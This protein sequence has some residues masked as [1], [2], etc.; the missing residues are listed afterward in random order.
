MAGV[1]QRAEE[2]H[3]QLRQ[4]AVV[5]HR[6]RDVLLAV[7]HPDLAQVAAIGAQ[8]RHLSPLDAA[9]QTSWLSTPFSRSPFHNS[10]QA[11]LDQRLGL[12]ERRL[13]LAGGLRAKS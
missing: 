4:L 10:P 8:Q 6:L 2:A 12:L 13:L 11:L 9:E 7:G 3:E 5:D 1:E